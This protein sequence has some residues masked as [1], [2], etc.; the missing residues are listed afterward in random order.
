MLIQ[1]D[2]RHL[3]IKSASVQCVVTSPPYWGLRDYGIPPSDW[4][5]WRGCLGL[6]PTPDFYLKHMVAVFREVWRV[7][8]TDGTL[9]LNMGDCYATGAGKVGEAPGGGP[10]GEKFKRHFGKSTPGSVPAMAGLTQP[11]RM[12]I[13]GLKPKDL[14]GMPWRVAFALQADG[15]WLRSDIIWAK[16]N[17]MPESVTDRPTKSHEYLFLL[18]KSE[19]YYYDS[20][21]I[22]EPSVTNDP[23]RPYTSEGA[24]QM[25]GRPLEQRHGGEPRSFKGSQFHTGKTGEHQLGRSQQVR[26]PAGWKTGKGSHGSIHADGREQE[27]QY[28]TE[29]NG[30]TRNKRSVWTI[31]TETY[32]GAHFATFPQKLVETCILAGS[33]PGDIVF[34]PFVGSGTVIRVATRLQRRSVGCDLNLEYLSQQADKRMRDVQVELQY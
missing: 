28:N 8:R 13:P 31:A 20:G 12:P 16:P 17:P 32:S 9:W 23:R 15:W 5:D 2:S 33:R 29:I 4:G 22:K 25:D 7:L 27:V 26:S 24:W 14:V 3:P 18:A 1:A 6:E 21:A 19:R 34:D 30:D 10:Q 11:N